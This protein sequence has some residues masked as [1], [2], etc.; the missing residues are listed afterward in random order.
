MPIV[1]NL[2][3]HTVMYLYYGLTA[4]GRQVPWK[5]VVTILQISQ[6]VVDVAVCWWGLHMYYFGSGGCAGDLVTSWFGAL[7]LSS[8]LILFVDFYLK[9]YVLSKSAPDA[10]HTVELK[11]M[12]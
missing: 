3:V 10:F 2:A 4:S 1:A 12:V 9:T 6:F 7:L 5:R 8:Y 11:K